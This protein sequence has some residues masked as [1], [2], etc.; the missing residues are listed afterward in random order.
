[1][2]GFAGSPAP[3][4]HIFT[5][6]ETGLVCLATQLERSSNRFSEPIAINSWSQMQGGQSW[7]LPKEIN[8][9]RFFWDSHWLKIWKKPPNGGSA[10]MESGSSSATSTSSRSA[11]WVGRF[12]PNHLKLLFTLQQEWMLPAARHS[13]IR[14]D[15]HDEKLISNAGGSKLDF[16]KR[17]QCK[18][19]LLRLLLAGNL[20]KSLLSLYGTEWR[21]RGYGLWISGKTGFS[22]RYQSTLAVSSCN[23]SKSLCH[24][25]QYIG[26]TGLNLK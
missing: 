7:I 26:K 12:H 1:M 6:D 8:A 25:N 19:V 20:E 22:L 17:D 13:L 2:T 21:E 3:R 15:S 4:V 9:N 11:S 14:A 23:R 5:I 24:L 16:A 18:P 10:A